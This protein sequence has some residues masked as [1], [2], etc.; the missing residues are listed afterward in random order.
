MVIPVKQVRHQNPDT[1]SQLQHPT[2]EHK[3]KWFFNTL[4]LNR[5]G[6]GQESVVQLS[7]DM[8]NHKGHKNISIC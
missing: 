3:N 5:A 1:K 6:R 7:G 8:A 4:F 2:L